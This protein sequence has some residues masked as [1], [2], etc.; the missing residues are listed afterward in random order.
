MNNDA[1]DNTQDN[2]TNYHKNQLLFPCFILNK[3]KN[4]ENKEKHAKDDIVDKPDIA[5]PASAVLLLHGRG[6]QQFLHYSLLSPPF[7]PKLGLNLKKI[8]KKM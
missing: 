2:Q 5:Q 6:F 3:T 1:N 7:R 4:I 8:P